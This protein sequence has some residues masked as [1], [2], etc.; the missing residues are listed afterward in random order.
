VGR[1]TWGA[2]AF[3]VFAALAM[4]ATG[5]SAG[6][7]GSMTACLKV[8]PGEPLG[9]AVYTEWDNERRVLEITVAGA[10]PGNYCIFVDKVKLDAKL[11]VDSTGAGYLKLDTNWGDDVPIIVLGSKIALKWCA[12]T[13]VVMCGSFM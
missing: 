12:D 7:I 3:A 6:L 10:E 13:T 11:Y 5:A 8:V 2:V 4:A 9:T 1:K